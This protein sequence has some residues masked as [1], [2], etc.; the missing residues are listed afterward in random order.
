EVA[1]EHGCDCWLADVASVAFAEARNDVVEGRQLEHPD[2]VEEL[3]AAQGEVLT[4]RSID[5]ES[6]LRQLALEHLLDERNAGAALR[7]R[8]AA[9]LQRTEFGAALLM[10]ARANR[11]GRDR[12][13][14][15]HKRVIRKLSAVG[16]GGTRH[17]EIRAGV[18]AQLRT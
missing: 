10:D 17:R 16:S 13:T 14:G 11:T 8:T 9:C 6:R 18:G 5:G 4:Q 3:L 2:G 15:T 12:V 7:T 1:G